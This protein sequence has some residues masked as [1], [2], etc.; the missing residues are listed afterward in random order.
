MSETA[1]MADVVDSNLRKRIARL[2]IFKTICRELEEYKNQCNETTALIGELNAI[3][4]GKK[5]I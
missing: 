4:G 5:D 1:E 3:T 2:R